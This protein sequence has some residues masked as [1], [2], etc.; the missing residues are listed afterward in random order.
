MV[1]V[2]E[3]VVTAELAHLAGRGLGEAFLAKPESGVPERGKPVEIALAAGVMDVDP[4]A[5]N[6]DRRAFLLVTSQVR[7]TVQH[8][9]D[10]TGVQGAFRDVHGA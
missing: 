9:G 6:D 2:T 5:A 1:H 8:V 10:V 7:V 4:L 3:I